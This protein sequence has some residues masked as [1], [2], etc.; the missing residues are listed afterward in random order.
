MNYV[1]FKGVNSNTIPGLLICE[2]PSITKPKMRYEAT[3]IDGRDGNITDE[4]GYSAYIKEMI[5]GIYGSS[6]YRNNN[7]N[8]IEL[9]NVE[10]NEN[11]TKLNKNLNKNSNVY[12]I[13]YDIDAISKYFSG[14]G[15]ITFSNEP[16]K[17]YNVSFLD[18]IDFE[19]L[20]KF[21]TSRVKIITQPFKYLKDEPNVDVT[22]TDQTLIEVTNQGLETS[23]PIIKLYGTEIVEILINGLS[24]FQLNYSVNPDIPDEYL[25]VNS[26]I[27]E[28]YKDTP[29]SLKNRSM[30]GEFPI[31][32]PGENQ[33][34]WIGNITR[35]VV[36][37]K[38]KWI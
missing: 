28:C 19:R 11:K 2:L 9:N 3:E 17:Y 15:Q 18:Q 38:S 31:L 14:S 25:T 22:I 6:I 34:K 8:G 13:G 4:L 23:K 16:D 29:G 12:D 7:L 21:K 32:Y 20:V 24:I 33:I 5:I 37:P 26:E 10:L 35:I 30:A 27:E 1:I 36:E